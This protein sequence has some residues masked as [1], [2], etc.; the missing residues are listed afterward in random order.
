MIN[1]KFLL[2]M[3]GSGCGKTTLAM[4][5][6]S[7]DPNVYH[8]PIEYGT[9]EIRDGEV[10]GFDYF[11]ITKD[12]LYE[13]EANGELIEVVEYQFKDSYGCNINQI[14]DGK[15]NIVVVSIEGFITIAERLKKFYPESD[16]ILVNI[17]ND[18]ELDIERAGRDPLQEERFNRSVLLHML[19]N[20]SVNPTT[21]SITGV[22]NNPKWKENIRYHELY[23][24]TLKKIRNSKKDCLEY[25][26]GLFN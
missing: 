21:Y 15:I 7:F 20:V 9:R 2:L 3:G 5:L 26:Y 17:I 1:T 16:V 4:K 22:F 11:F 12:E 14:K 25:F 19:D 13:L 8:R 23:L 24:S 10:N 18:C 6:E